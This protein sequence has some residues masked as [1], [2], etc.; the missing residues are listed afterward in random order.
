[1]KRCMKKRNAFV[2]DIEKEEIFKRDNWVCGIC[3][4]RVRKTFR[5]PN[6]MAATLDHVVSLAKGGKHE[7]SNVQLAHAAC[8]SGKRDNRYETQLLLGM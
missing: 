5:Y 1:M 2:E 3:G 6:K 7:K 8:N 4:K